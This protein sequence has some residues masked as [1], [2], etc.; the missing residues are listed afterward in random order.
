MTKWL[1]KHSK[2]RA[3]RIEPIE[4]KAGSAVVKIYPMINRGRR[5][6]TVTHYPVAGQRIRQNFADLAKAKQEA[7][8][9]A[10]SLQ[11]G[12]IS[13]LKLSNQDHSAYVHAVA[14]VK[15]T[16]RSLELAATEFAE[17]VQM[18]GNRTSLVEAVRFY[19][20]HHPTTLP[21]KPI[22][23]V[24]DEMI[25]A[26]RADGMSARYLSDLES[27]LGRFARECCGLLSDLTSKDL[28]DW[29][30]GLGVGARGRNNFRALLIALF[31]FAKSC[32]YLPKNQETEADSLTKAKDTASAIE[33]FS[34]ADLTKLLE[35]ADDSLVPYLA[36]GAFAGLRTAELQRLIWQEVKLD[37]G[38][39]EV[40][41]GKAKT[42]QRR[43]VPI[44]P[45]LALWLQRH[46]RPAGEVFLLSTINQ[47]AAGFSK[48]LG[49]PWPHNGLRHSY[50]SYRLAKC[51][52]AAEVALEMGNSPRMIFQHYRELV[53][54]SDAEKWW[55]IVPAKIEKVVSLKTVG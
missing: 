14:K 5:L 4:V 10:A 32:G 28:K 37:Q 41:A 38:F 8:R 50:A 16:G 30:N 13:V 15:P 45:N 18:L 40:T 54:P 12:D 3:K 35:H 7:Y 44:Q 19:V 48:K 42:A 6:Y 21:K 22:R 46:V 33:I 27:R 51:K 52:S 29:L 17:A 1:V 55:D 49:I 53:T 24:V 23:H 25:S 39:I 34:P 20:K 43:L 2:S 47:K 9:L 26:K 36:I 11:N 31:N